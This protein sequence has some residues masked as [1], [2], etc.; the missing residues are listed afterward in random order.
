MSNNKTT[1]T[2]EAGTGGQQ[3]VVSSAKFKQ[4]DYSLYFNKGP[5]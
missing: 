3:V 4:H 2:N 5:W 1:I